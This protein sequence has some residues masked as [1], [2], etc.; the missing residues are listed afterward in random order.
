MFK[1]TM[2]ALA[3]A[4]FGLTACVAED[5]TP[6]VDD[7]GFGKADSSHPVGEFAAASSVEAG[8]F[9]SLSLNDDRTFTRVERD[10][11]PQGQGSCGS[12]IID[13]T[14][15]FTT[16]GSKH[17]IRFLVNGEL[18]DRYT[19]TY[20][21]K[22]LTLR[23]D[24]GTEAAFKL[25]LQEPHIGGNGDPCDDDRNQCGDGFVCCDTSGTCVDEQT[26]TCDNS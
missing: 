26:G 10:T 13:G 22:T 15:K 21:N 5:N 1:T 17:F 4:A 18:R 19:Y 25:K 6:E 9:S 8:Q 20:A 3:F 14:Y 7:S 23:L 24:S 12:E 2:I 11:C 16:S